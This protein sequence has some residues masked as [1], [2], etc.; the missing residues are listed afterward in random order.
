MP[1]ITGSNIIVYINGIPFAQSTGFKYSVNY[2]RKNLMSID[3]LLPVEITP[4]IITVT[5]SV[6]FIKIHYDGGIEGSNVVPTIENIPNEK[7][8]TIS[9][10][11]LSNGLMIFHVNQA[12]VQN[13]ALSMSPKSILSGTFAFSAIGYQNELSLTMPS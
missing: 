6:G 10:V 2:S 7:Y 9:L 3:S 5:G 4:G 12:M 8:I 1:T 13:Q 11:D